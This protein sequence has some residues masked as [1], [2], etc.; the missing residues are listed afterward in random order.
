MEALLVI[1]GLWFLASPLAFLALLVSGRGGSSRVDTV[2]RELFASRL[3]YDAL[4]QR[5]AVLEGA[6]ASG[7][8]ALGPYRDPAA[9][10][11]PVAVAARAR[12]AVAWP[13]GSQAPDD[14][15]PRPRERQDMTTGAADRGDATRRR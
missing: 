1:G 9:T 13:S 6:L 3:G 10:A 8:R 5:L 12:P 4:A 7:V 14:A 15:A 11:L 2:E